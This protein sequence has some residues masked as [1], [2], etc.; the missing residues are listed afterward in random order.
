MYMITESKV[1]E[2]SCDTKIPWQGSLN[3]SPSAKSG[4]LSVFV[5]KVSLDYIQPCPFVWFCLGCFHGTTA[6]LNNCKRVYKN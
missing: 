5:Y 4:L 3:H 1:F 2:F 6:E